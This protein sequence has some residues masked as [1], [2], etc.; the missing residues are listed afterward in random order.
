MSN[1]PDAEAVIAKAAHGLFGVAVKLVAWVLP[2]SGR[3]QQ[4]A[5]RAGY[6]EGLRDGAGRG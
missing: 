3:S 4:D 1:Q 5:W 2:W 6:A